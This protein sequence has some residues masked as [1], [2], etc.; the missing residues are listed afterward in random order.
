MN[1]KFRFNVETVLVFDTKHIHPDTVTKLAETHHVCSSLRG[2]ANEK[3][4]QTE[5]VL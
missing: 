4:R 2:L 3:T 5:L 1:S